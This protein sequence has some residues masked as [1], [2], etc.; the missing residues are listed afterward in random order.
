MTEKTRKR[1]VY[2]I[3]VTAVI[4]GAW[5]LWP[6]SKTSTLTGSDVDPS[7]GA[8]DPSMT[9]V[10]AIVPP[11][12]NVAYD[13]WKHDPF[14]GKYKP[15]MAEQAY[16]EP[17]SELDLTVISSAGDNFMAIVNGKVLSENGVVED[18]V[19]MK[20]DK[21]SVL[22]KKGDMQQRLHLKRR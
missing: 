9:Q 19:V 15:R 14:V 2:L 12:H 1:I 17:E 13:E 8:N 6:R 21:S 22:L 20:I 16:E 5:N 18:W 3:L 11:A 10:A 7:S 4:W